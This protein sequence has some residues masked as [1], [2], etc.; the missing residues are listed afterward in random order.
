MDGVTSWTAIQRQNI[1]SEARLR[2][3]TWGWGGGSAWSLK[4]ESLGCFYGPR[5]L[6]V[7]MIASLARMLQH[8][9]TKDASV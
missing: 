7:R 9:M 5:C 8:T 4:C 1:A 6:G 3:Q 2:E